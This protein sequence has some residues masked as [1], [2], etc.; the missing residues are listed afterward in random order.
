MRFV[1]QVTETGKSLVYLDLQG[2]KLPGF[3]FDYTP[4][5]KFHIETY[6]VLKSKSSSMAWDIVFRTTHE[7]FDTRPK[8]EQLGFATMLVVMHYEIIDKLYTQDLQVFNNNLVPLETTLSKWLD[9]YDQKVDLVPH[10]RAWVER[11]VPIQSFVGV[12]ERP[13]DSAATTFYREDVVDLTTLV[14]V[15]KMMTPIFGIFIEACKKKIGNNLKE[16]HCLAITKLLFKHRFGPLID[17]LKFFISKIMKP[18]LSKLAP[19][20]LF[21]GYTFNT[22]SDEVYSRLITRQYVTVDLFKDNGNLMTY[23]TSCIR[24]AST[25]QCSM[26]GGAKTAAREMILPLS[27]QVSINDEGNSSNLEA[28]SRSSNSTADYAVLIKAAANKAIDSFIAEQDIDPELAESCFYYYTVHHIDP[29]P[30][31]S[32]ILSI[33][34]GRA[35]G[36]AKSIAMLD[37]VSYSKLLALLQIYFSKSGY[38]VLVN[39]LTLKDTGELKSQFTGNDTQLRAIWNSSYEYK[40][41]N[42]RFVGSIGELTWDTRLKE[43]IE[44]ITSTKYAYNTAPAIWDML[45]QESHNGEVFVVDTD[46]SRQICSLVMEL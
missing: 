18:V 12:G 36:G 1:K 22:A 11:N 37:R 39:P 45:H 9:E 10:L 30:I 3:K 8:S 33:V 25:T 31:N 16:I 6:T 24:A 4:L 41:C 43:I 35:L 7:L 2:E 38:E 14:L 32:F 17:K 19:S 27:N 40:A 21:N 29:T 5:L 20:H 23:T 44:N 13:Q 42:E 15:C 26:A 46:L 28:E 34:F